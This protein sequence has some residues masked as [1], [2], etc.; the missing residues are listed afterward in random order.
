M[1]MIEV[2][3]VS[4]AYNGKPVFEN[5]S[6]DLD[7]G[8]VLCLF[9]PNGCG[10]TTLIDI[11]LGYLK[12]ARGAVYIEGRNQREYSRGELA[13]RIAYV[14]QMHERTFPHRVL[15]IVVMGRTPYL[16]PLSSPGKEDYR[17]AEQALEMIGIEHLKNRIYTQLSGGETQLVILARA[18]TQKAPVILMDEPAAHLD[19]R[20]ELVLLETIAGLVHDGGISVVMST[21]SPNHPFYFENRDIKTRVALMDSG[22]IV[23]AGSPGDIM[24]EKVMREVFSMETRVFSHIHP[25]HNGI[26]YI[27][28]LGIVRQRGEDEPC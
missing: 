23:A 8:E 17:M 21:H 6:L 25:D 14:P 2:R 4:F 13:R 19:F 15:D 26:R 18:L 9:G 7:R 12:P 22:G 1:N 5:I 16:S 20:F 11:I 28:P 3:D 27:V 10:K 24:S